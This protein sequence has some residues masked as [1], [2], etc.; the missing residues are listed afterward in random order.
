MAKVVA[1]HVL[2]GW[3]RVLHDLKD[4]VAMDI[5]QLTTGSPKLHLGGLLP[6]HEASLVSGLAPA[7]LLRAAAQGAMS[8]FIDPGVRPG[9]LVQLSD[10]DYDPESGGYDIL[11]PELMPANAVADDHPGPVLIE[12]R[13]VKALVAELIEGQ[14][15]KLLAFRPPGRPKVAYCPTGGLLVNVRGLQVRGSEVEALRAKL[16]LKITPEQLAAAQREPR[17][18]AVGAKGHLSVSA[19]I[20]A[21]IDERSR[22]CAPDQARRIRAACELFVHLMGDM[23]VQTVTRNMLRLYRDKRLPLVPANESKSQRAGRQR[24]RR[25]EGERAGVRSACCGWRRCGRS[26]WRSSPS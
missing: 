19:A 18:G 24:R 12:P 4:R 5:L 9:F 16:A 20:N 26:S 22:R 1:T 2:A 3:R 8:L 25:V 11:P 13:E 23:P 14:G 6:L 21:F 17:S 10:L 7:D 15:C